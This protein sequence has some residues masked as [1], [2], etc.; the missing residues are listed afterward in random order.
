MYIAAVL[1]KDGYQVF[2][3]DGCEAALAICNSA[4]CC[5]DLI[6]TDVGMPRMNRQELA[7]C[8]NLRHPDAPI[9]FVSGHPK[10]RDVLAGL[11]DFGF[12]NGYTYLQKPFVP[13]EL[14]AVARTA[15]KASHQVANR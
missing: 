13:E 7:H 5:F 14:L 8:I 3:A 9:I 15:L 10:S 1:R 4:A 6:I 12:K 11:T 2:Q